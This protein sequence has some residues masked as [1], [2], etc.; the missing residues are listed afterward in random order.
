MSK[1]ALVVVESPAKSRTINKI[2]GP[3]YV[4]L[5]SMGHIMDLPKS[6]MGIDVEK[7]FKP[8]YIVISGRKKYLTQLKEQAKNA[9]VIYLAPDPDREGEA[10]SWHLKNQLGKKK[11]VLRVA[12]DEITATAV[13]KAFEHPRAIDTNLVNAQQARRILDR[14]VGY[15]LSPILW[16]KVT[17][18]LSAGRV[19]SVAVRLVVD[20]E[21][22]IRKFKPDE[23]WELEAGLRKKSAE[24]RSFSASLEKIDKK[25]FCIKDENEAKRIKE[26][27]RKNE[28]IVTEI[29][30][31]KKSRRPQA[32]F[33]TS[34]LQQD[35]FNKLRFQ[36]NRTMRIAQGLY[37]G[38]E[39]EEKESVGLIT[40]MRTDSVKVSQDAQ[41]AAQGYIKKAYGEKYYPAK[42]NV[43]K[44]RKSAQEAHECI[45]PTLPLREPGSVK[46]FLTTDQFKLYELIW[47]R[48]I[49]SQM[50]NAA[51][52][53][54]TVEI[55]AGIY[56]FKTS[57]TKILFD[58]FTALY[59]TSD[60]P[61][62]GEQRK[63]LWRIPP[64]VRGE[65][66]DLLSLNDS[67]HFTKAPARYSDATLVKVLEEAGIGRPS[68]YAPIIYTIIMR[69][70]VKRIKGYLYPTEL[71]EIINGLL[72]KHFPK[73]MDT[74]FTAKIEDKLDDVEEGKL[75]WVQV[76]KDFYG[77]FMHAV[78]EAKKHMKSVKTEGVETNEVCEMCKKPMIIKWGRRGKFLSCSD[79]PRC[80]YAKSITTGVKCPAPDCEGELIERR[81]S[82][83]PF[84]G[85][86]KYPNC[87]Y[88]SRALPEKDEEPGQ[89]EEK[90]PAE[91]KGSDPS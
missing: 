77:P 53:V 63:G 87:K 31:Q 28:F 41:A 19:Q 80:K 8:Q 61:E 30:E 27:I 4:V 69:N 2:L 32:P 58:G 78:G 7:D 15:S 42:P 10:I 52:S 91:K 11:K 45:R 90:G 26:D 60:T 6:K 56:L 20:R 3:G 88:T 21:A 82:R 54:T 35:A 57:G 71:G 40:Y 74:G 36:V 33:T 37:E 48:F 47:K 13:K 68:T 49:S 9:D 22:E 72:V 75:D 84:Y 55:E 66:L 46:S 86:T 83:G 17:R 38:V 65:K 44:S 39:L 50:V 23:Y 43:Y 34:K 18:G 16:K 14:I 81:S 29:K 62:E 25:A 24:K 89:T 59:S 12:F 85:C 79:F 70:Y 64:L 67:Q 5:A 1:K 76:L 73:I 51:H